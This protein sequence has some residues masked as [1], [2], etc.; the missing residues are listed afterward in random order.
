MHL[1]L[2]TSKQVKEDFKKG[3]NQAVFLKFILEDK[4]SNLVF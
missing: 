3:F 2:A 1:H 4:N